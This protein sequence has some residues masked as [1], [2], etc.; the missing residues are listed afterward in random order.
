MSG[1]R[2]LLFISFVLLFGL[3]VCGMVSAKAPCIRGEYHGNSPQ[4]EEGCKQ[5]VTDFCKQRGMDVKDSNLD[6]ASLCNGE[7]VTDE[8]GCN[9]LGSQQATQADL[10]YVSDPALCQDTYYLRPSDGAKLVLEWHAISAPYPNE[11]VCECFG[12]PT[13]KAPVN[14]LCGNGVLDGNEECDLGSKNGDAGSGCTSDCKI[15]LGDVTLKID[16]SYRQK[17]MKERLFDPVKYG[18]TPFDDYDCMV[19]IPNALA[20]GIGKGQVKKFQSRLSVPYPNDIPVSPGLQAKGYTT[21]MHPFVATGVLI[22]GGTKERFLSN[23]KGWSKGL[24]VTEVDDKLSP[25]YNDLES[26]RGLWNL[27]KSHSLTCE[28]F[29]GDQNEILLGKSGELKTTNCIKLWGPDGNTADA[30]GS[31]IPEAK[32]KFSTRNHT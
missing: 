9:S 31:V 28:V 12:N 30:G 19:E 15:N 13:C 4:S 16:D 32:F 21:K 14:T 29:L 22:N 7:C 6:S 5:D 2:G 1:K 10:R 17:T 24:F 20:E 25:G 27:V 26:F 3:I 18:P 23:Y 8:S 11:G